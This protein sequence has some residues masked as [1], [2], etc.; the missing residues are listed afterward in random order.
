MLPVTSAKEVGQR[1]PGLHIVGPN[2]WP[3]RV[4]HEVSG[5]RTSLC[6][7]PNQVC[8][9]LLSGLSSRCRPS[10]DT[11]TA[12]RFTGLCTAYD[13]PARSPR[14]A[15]CQRAKRGQETGRMKADQSW[16]QV[17]SRVISVVRVSPRAKRVRP[18]MPGRLCA[19]TG[20][21]TGS[22]QKKSAA[23]DG[24]YSIAV[25]RSDLRTTDTAAGPCATCATPS[26]P[27]KPVLTQSAGRV[28]GSTKSRC[29]GTAT[30]ALVAGRWRLSSGQYP[31]A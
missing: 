4:E 1:L 12:T 6:Q 28:A 21:E 2:V 27:S 3:W 9:P 31:V 13:R 22:K 19:S 8:A 17:Q 15:R 14:L 29:A 20:C 10:A 16:I 26:Q 11:N 23:D 30:G 25:D 18:G 24:E 5:H 7:R